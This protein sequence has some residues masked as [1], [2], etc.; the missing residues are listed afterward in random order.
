MLHRRSILAAM[1][2]AAFTHS[3][4]T[5]TPAARAAPLVGPTSTNGAGIRA[6]SRT[7]GSCGTNPSQSM[8]WSK[9]AARMREYVVALE[10]K[11]EAAGWTCFA[12]PLD[13]GELEDRAWTPAI[14]GVLPKRTI[15]HREILHPER[16]HEPGYL[17]DVI[18]EH[19]RG[20][21]LTST[22]FKVVNP[23][24]WA[25]RAVNARSGQ[26]LPASGP[27]Q[28]P[29]RRGAARRSKRPP[30]ARV[31]L[32]RDH[33]RGLAGTPIGQSARDRQ[34]RRTAR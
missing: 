21:F 6:E 23:E 14:C 15:V 10:Q 25:L 24:R 19:Q 30:K 27:P 7:I 18:E 20:R 13:P 17:T 28:R 33:V 5:V 11:L 34:R 12:I 8:P 1:T 22:P 29:L 31:R 16:L 26:A 4:W 2:L 9:P 3:A 32:L